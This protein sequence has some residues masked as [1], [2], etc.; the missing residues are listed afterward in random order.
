MLE[1][2]LAVGR[3]RAVDVQY[4]SNG[5]AIVRAEVRFG[6]WL[7]KPGAPDGYAVAVSA[8]HLGAAPTARL[9]IAS[10]IA[11]AGPKTL[12]VLCYQQLVVVNLP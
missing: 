9:A 7:E 8:M 12:V 1:P 11:L 3:A 10:K 6:D 2:M 5:G 4:Q